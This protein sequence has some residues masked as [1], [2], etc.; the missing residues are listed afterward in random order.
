MG[1][2]DTKCEIADFYRFFF[3][4]DSK[5]DESASDASA[6]ELGLANVGGVFVVLALGCVAALLMAI[7]EFVWNIRKIAVEE[8]VN[9]CLR[10]KKIGTNHVWIADNSQGSSCQGTQ[11]R[12][13]VQ[14]DH[15]TREKEE[16]QQQKL[17][18][19]RCFEHAA[20]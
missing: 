20:R 17:S 12:S 9:F 6:A 19:K 13:R 7:L 3:P 4:R 2:T 5:G 11:I 16:E 1:C 14:R 15:E 10:A 18:G 8:E